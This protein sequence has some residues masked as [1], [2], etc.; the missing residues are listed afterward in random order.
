[1]P[2]GFTPDSYP[3]ILASNILSGGESSRLYRKLVY[4]DRIA[5]QSAGFGQFTED[6]NLFLAFAIM[7]QGKTPEEGEKAVE[8]ILE[9]I[10]TTPVEA[11]E[12]EKAKN[13]QVSAFILGR[14]TV[15]EIADALGHDAVIGGDPELLNT[16]LDRFLRVTPEDIQR[17]AREYF[18]AARRTVLVV[19]T[20]KA[21]K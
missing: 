17:V 19:E 10:K 13:Q 5:V 9:Q 20:P 21:P 14:E 4:E 16:D 7:N 6:P 11:K 15:Q 8:G 3:L 2:A 12:L 1:M 18:T